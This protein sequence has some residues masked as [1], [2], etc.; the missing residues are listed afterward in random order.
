[1]FDLKECMDRYRVLE[2]IA[3]WEVEVL[4]KEILDLRQQLT[5]SRLM[6]E[7]YR[8]LLVDAYVELGLSRCKKEDHEQAH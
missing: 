6:T 5:V 7:H 4:F 3:K 1:M 2:C 8:R